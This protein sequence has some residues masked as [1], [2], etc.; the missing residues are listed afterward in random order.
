MPDLPAIAEGPLF[1]VDVLQPL[2]HLLHSPFGGKLVVRLLNVHLEKWPSLWLADQAFLCA[3]E[4]PVYA[5][6][7]GF[8]LAWTPGTNGPITVE[9]CGRH[10]LEADFAKYHGKLKGKALLSLIRL[11]DAPHEGGRAA[12]PT[13]EEIVAREAAARGARGRSGRG[14]GAAEEQ[15]RRCTQSRPQR[16]RRPGEGEWEYTPTSLALAQAKNGACATRSDAFLKEEAWRFPSLRDTT[17]TAV[18]SFRRMGG[19]ENPKDPIRLRSSPLGR[20][21]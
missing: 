7:T 12:F 20:A 18:R 13:D 1:Q 8:P 2:L 4:T 9:R 16:A 17:E 14:C 15:Q 19:S 5:A 10:P 21:V 6:F 3:M 11:T